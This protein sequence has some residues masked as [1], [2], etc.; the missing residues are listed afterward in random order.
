[1]HAVAV[2]VDAALVTIED[3]VVV[4]VQIVLVADAVAVGVGPVGDGAQ[5][6]GPDGDGVG[7]EGR[8]PRDRRREQ[9]GEGRGD[10]GSAGGSF[11]EHGE[12]W[13]RRPRF[14]DDDGPQA[15][16]R[17]GHPSVPGHRVMPARRSR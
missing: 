9:T 15:N 13:P 11:L 8:P 12:H 16:A 17:T 10:G 1:M 3:A 6:E 7:R 5:R 14:V 4:V 2:R